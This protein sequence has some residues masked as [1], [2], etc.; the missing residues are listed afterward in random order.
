M[1]QI[2]PEGK[3]VFTSTLHARQVQYQLKKA[4]YTYEVGSQRIRPGAYGIM[5][6]N[7]WEGKGNA[8]KTMCTAGNEQVLKA[9]GAHRKESIHMEETGQKANPRPRTGRPTTVLSVQIAQQKMTSTVF[10]IF[11]YMEG[12]GY[13]FTIPRKGKKAEKREEMWIAFMHLL[14][15]E[16]KDIVYRQLKIAMN[17]KYKTQLGYYSAP[18]KVY[19]KRFAE[20]PRPKGLKRRVPVVIG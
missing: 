1:K 19:L 3:I 7:E 16:C 17:E 14:R 12:L 11:D 15:D 13:D 6:S 9:Y 20:L 18:D 4:G 5:W 10:E 2:Y 8:K